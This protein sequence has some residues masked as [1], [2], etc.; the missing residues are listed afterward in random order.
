MAVN[1]WG[2]GLSFHTRKRERERE[3][4]RMARGKQIQTGSERPCISETAATFDMRTILPMAQRE[5]GREGNRGTRKMGSVPR[6]REAF[7]I[8][9]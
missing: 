3:R 2:G 8:G 9:N 4:E 7:P 1:E 5:R 6:E